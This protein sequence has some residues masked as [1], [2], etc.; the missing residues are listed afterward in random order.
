MSA[1]QNRTKKTRVTG[2]SVVWLASVVVVVA[3][4]ADEVAVLA[5]SPADW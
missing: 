5:P 4:P 2:T 1:P 3:G